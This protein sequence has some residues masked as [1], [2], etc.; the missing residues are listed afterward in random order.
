MKRLRREWGYSLRSYPA[1]K[2]DIE[3]T[4]LLNHLCESFN[5]FCS[6]LFVL[7]TNS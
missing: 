3:S 5:R 2:P 7:S 1:A 6:L 4:L